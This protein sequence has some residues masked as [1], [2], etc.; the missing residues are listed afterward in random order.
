MPLSERRQ[1]TPVPPAAARVEPPHAWMSRYSALRAELGV[2][3]AVLAIV[4]G[5]LFWLAKT[6]FSIRAG[7][8]APFGTCVRTDRHVAT[9]IQT[10]EPYVP[11]LH[12]DHGKDRY[13]LSVLLVPLDGGEPRVVP[14][15]RG[16]APSEYALA[17]VLGSHGGELWVEARGV[18]AIRLDTF[19]VRAHDGPVPDAVRPDPRSRLQPDP[20]GLLAAGYIAA[21]GVWIG[22]CSRAE[23]AREYA[24][25]KFVRRVE[26]SNGTKLARRLHRARLEPDDTGRYHRITAVEPLGDA[27]YVGAAFLR[28]AGGAE[29]YRLADPAGAL[30]LFTSD[31]GLAG[32]LVVARTDDAGALLWRTDTGIDRFTLQQIL[33]GATST[34]FVGTRPRVPDRVPEPLLV[35][36]DHMTGAR[37]EHSLWR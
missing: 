28:P 16:L 11:S 15:H 3:V 30:L 32:T 8:G 24:I 14:V 33:P 4:F 29:P 10:L 21:P 23:L 20:S 17:R 5:G 7:K 12:R 13:T 37:T 9:W 36:V 19:A 6:M 35:L 25:G 34:A 1:G 26:S 2:V 22:A 18:S 27:E 31:A